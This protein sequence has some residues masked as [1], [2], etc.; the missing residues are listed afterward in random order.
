M[1][2]HLDKEKCFELDARLMEQLKQ[3]YD[4]CCE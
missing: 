3:F 2:A 4:I 1:N